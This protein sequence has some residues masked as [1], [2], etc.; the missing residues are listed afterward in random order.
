MF[1][2]LLLACWTERSTLSGTLAWV[3]EEQGGA[4]SL[5]WA[6]AGRPH[7]SHGLTAL[8]GATFPAEADPRGTHLLVVSSQDGPAGHRE[9]LWLVPKGG[10]DP[11][12]LGEPATRIRNPAWSPDGSWIAYESDQ[13]AFRE[14]LRVDRDGSG[15]ERLTR[16]P[17]GDFEPD[18]AP[19]GT[20]A[21]V[22]S[23]DGNAEVYIMNEDGA[24]PFRITHQAGNDTNPTWSPDGQELAFLT[25]RGE[26]VQ[27]VRIARGEVTPR[28]VR[29]APVPSEVDHAVV[30]SPKGD[31]L[32]ITTHVGQTGLA[33][34]LVDLEGRRI[35]R[36]DGP[37]PD[38]H[39]VFSPD[40][41][42]LLFTSSR[43]GQP[44]LYVANADG[45]AIRPLVRSPDPEWLPRWGP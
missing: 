21:F 39:P 44:D 35:A 1:V 37:G 10:G 31:R 9:R 14:I 3:S 18:I 22:S 5:R 42:H 7:D 24:N 17:K 29:A 36:I 45:S 34:D 4:P 27:A 32:A 6:S 13:H 15:V 16:N 23:R 20:V 2:V 33:I 28:P 41:A 25:W 38:E 26:V 19:D 12:P 11:T 30:W 8:P 40:G 43:E